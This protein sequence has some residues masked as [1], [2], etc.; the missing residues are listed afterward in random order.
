[1]VEEIVQATAIEEVPQLPQ[2]LNTTNDI[3]TNTL[4]LLFNNLDTVQNDTNVTVT[5]SEVRSLV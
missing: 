5:T 2:D 1:M 4:D 3:I